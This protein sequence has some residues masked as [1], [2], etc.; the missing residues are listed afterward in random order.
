MGVAEAGKTGKDPSME[1]IL[2]SI[3][4]IIADEDTPQNPED[5]ILELTEAM[6]EAPDE[7]HVPG[8]LEEIDASLDLDNSDGFATDEAAEPAEPVMEI[9][10]ADDIDALFADAPAASAAEPV[11]EA[12]PIGDIQP[13]M[14]A[15]PA[16]QPEPKPISED[17]TLLDQ[18]TEQAA[19]QAF[20]KL[21]QADT[22]LSPAL[23]MDSP[24][25]RNGQT[26]EDLVLEAL[27]PMLKEWLDA[28]LPELVERLVEREIRRMAR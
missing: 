23:H 22:P 5:E 19:K 2:E 9:A 6:E 11:A 14:A 17:E 3:K 25:F 7:E 27:R 10:S 12:Q 16:P 26:V 28:N 24:A 18:V 13:E 15:K 8:V 21:K 1:E 20:E 4:R